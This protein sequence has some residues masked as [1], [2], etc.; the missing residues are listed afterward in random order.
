MN[1]CDAFYTSE[2]GSVARLREKGGLTVLTTTSALTYR[3]TS[4]RENRGIDHDLI[5]DF[6]DSYSLK[7]HYKFYENETAVTEALKKGEGDIA[8]ARLRSPADSSEFLAGPAYEETRLS[9]FCQTRLKI[10]NA[11]DLNQRSVLLMKRDNRNN[12]DQKL[13]QSAPHIQLQLIDDMSPLQLLKMVQTGKIDCAA[14][15][16]VS[17]RQAARYFGS[18]EWVTDLSEAYSLNWLLQPGQHDL[19]VLM[20]AWFQ[21]ASRNDEIMRVMDHYQAYLEELGKN[22]LRLF[23]RH[24]LRTLPQY[25]KTFIE[26]ARENKVPWQLVAAVAYQESNWDAEARSYTGVRGMMQLTTETAQHLGVEDRSDPIQ[27][28]QGGA[29]YLRYLLGRIPVS[30]NANDRLSLALAAYNI[31]LAHLHDAQKLAVH[32]GRNPYSWHHMREI[33]PL[34]T[35]DSYADQLEYGGARGNETVAFVERVKSFYSYMAAPH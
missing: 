16:Q 7:V 28:I 22:D 1:G 12:L 20:Q 19:W 29:K 11:K 4:R 23:R 18:V 31:G 8:A 25:Q 10:A 13:Q 2:T 3:S 30:V 33:L 5:Q 6:A 21:Q 15:E 17:G 34:L 26:A 32:M 35:I 27:S 14:I 24:L 9:L